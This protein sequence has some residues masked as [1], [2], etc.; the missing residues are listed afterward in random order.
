MPDELADAIAQGVVVDRC[1]IVF[2]SDVG[3]I[4]AKFAWSPKPEDRIGGMTRR[5]V[6]VWLPVETSHLDLFDA[7]VQDVSWLDVLF[8]PRE[9]ALGIAYDVAEVDVGESSS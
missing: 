9:I 6:S 4:E 1:G 2:D 3:A 5:A 8:E 7:R